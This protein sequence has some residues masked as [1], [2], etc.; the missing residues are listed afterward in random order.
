VIR[1]IFVL[2][3]SIA[4]YGIFLF[5]RGNMILR[6]AS[7]PDLQHSDLLVGQGPAFRYIAAGDSTAVGEGASNISSTYPNII[8]AY[9]AKNNSVTYR[10]IG[11]S[12]ARTEDLL[13]D[14]LPQIISFDPD[15]VTISIGANDLVRANSSRNILRNIEAILSS[16]TQETD[17]KIV[18]A[19][20][21]NFGG[22][23][24]LPS[25]YVR[26]LEWRASALN[27]KLFEM[28]TERI[29]IAN[30]HDRDGVDASST[31]AADHFHPNDLGY[32]GWS[33][34]FIQAISVD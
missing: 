4:V 7:L 1:S 17:A 10:N 23:N 31:Y 6:S 12:G 8:A 19:T 28:Q 9:L 22:A 30:I 3:I 21:P 27:R 14:Q 26:I 5:V 16:L 25:W 13:K 29:R 33:K 32:A 11:V 18:I 15:L 20:L 24:L 2:L 34:K